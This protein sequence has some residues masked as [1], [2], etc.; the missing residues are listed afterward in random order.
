MPFF[1]NILSTAWLAEQTTWFGSP[2][3]SAVG[4]ALPGLKYS[5]E[6]HS[7]HKAQL[8]TFASQFNIGFRQVYTC[9]KHIPDVGVALRIAF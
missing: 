4:R 6:T 7:L 5:Q 9:R 2:V 8:L 3:C 1:S